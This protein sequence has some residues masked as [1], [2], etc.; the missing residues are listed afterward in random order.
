MS[1]GA[2]HKKREEDEGV[3]GPLRRCIATG[4]AHAP[5]DMVRF[6]AAPNGGVVPDV[7]HKLPGRGMWVSATR[8]AITRAA[9]KGLFSKSAKAPLLIPPTLADDVEALLVKRLQDHLG[10]AR[11]AGIL[12][13]GFQKVEEAFQARKTKIEVLIEASESGAADRGKLINW[14]RKAGDIGVIGCLTGEEIGLALGRESVVHA[15]LTSHPLAARIFAEAKRL[16]GFRVLCPREWGAT[17]PQAQSV[18]D[19]GQ[20]GV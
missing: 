20:N 14:A 18:D 2:R 11:R 6:V 12:I 4:T 17:P 5:E 9:T 7:A 1:R 8:E 16:G 13:S 15:A 10:L 3:E 19:V